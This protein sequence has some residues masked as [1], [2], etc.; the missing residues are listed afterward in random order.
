MNAIGY[1]RIS[2]KDQSRYSLE[3]QQ[4]EVERYCERNQLKLLAVFKDNGQCSDTFD[5]PDWLALETFIREHKGAVRFLIIFDHDRFSRN[6]PEAL[7]KISSLEK[8]FGIR[9]IATNEAIDTDTTDPSVFLNRAFKYLIANHELIH[10]RKRTRMGIRQAMEN[11]RFVNMAPYGYKNARDESGRGIIL[12]DP[13]KS[14]L[15]Q[16]IFADF[17][18]GDSLMTIFRSVKGLGFPA[19]G[20][21][22]IQRILERSVYAGL[23][24]IVTA[25]GK[26][27]YIRAIHEA[28][29]PE[30]QFWT[31][32]RLL[33]PGRISRS[34]LTEEVPL[35]GLL[36]CWC[37]CSMTAGKSRGRSKYYTYYR[38][39]KHGKNFSAD[40]IHDKLRA[41]IA[42]LS[43]TPRQVAYIETAAK[44]KLE[45]AT[46]HRAALIEEKK[47]ALA[48]VAEK[49]HRMEE[50]Y[51]ND[52]IETSTYKKWYP[53]FMADQSALQEEIKN[54]KTDQSDKWTQLIRLFPYLQDLSVI[55]D[56]ADVVQKQALLKVWFKQSLIFDNGV[57]RT[58]W[59]NPAFAHNCVVLKEKGLLEVE[60]K[61][62]MTG[63]TP[64]CTRDGN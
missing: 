2:T 50:K 42:H 35:R 19:K 30:A 63:E 11:G 38:C 21:S 7:A 37:G 4:T 34:R 43:L 62:E 61:G 33:H 39:M 51:M 14:P 29:I 52:E 6:L 36:K 47:K 44:T 10:I 15:V 3:Y 22:A 16:K 28:I 40:M 32:Q 59:I 58:A 20:N 5:R 26:E 64:M 45:N 46:I 27:K 1:I 57:F 41:V 24:K 48:V 31:A 9:V 25:E 56:K 49:L 17:I 12:V 23:I 53:K 55:F 18:S 13:A 60:E 8:K 54:L